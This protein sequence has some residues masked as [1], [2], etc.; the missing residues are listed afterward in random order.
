MYATAILALAAVLAN[1][2]EMEAVTKRLVGEVRFPGFAGVSQ[3]RG[4][5]DSL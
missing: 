3:K 2:D 5:N 4:R 1:V